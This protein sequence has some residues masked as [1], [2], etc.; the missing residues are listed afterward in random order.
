VSVWTYGA[1]KRPFLHTSVCSCACP[2]TG[3]EAQAALKA[4]MEVLDVSGQDE[5]DPPEVRGEME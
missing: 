1:Q 2:L 4:V 5:A 3:P